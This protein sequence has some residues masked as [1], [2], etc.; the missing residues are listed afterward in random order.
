L[1]TNSK[2]LADGGSTLHAFPGNRGES[3]TKQRSVQWARGGCQLVPMGIIVPGT[4]IFHLG[5]KVAHLQ[6]SKRREGCGRDETYKEK[7]M[8]KKP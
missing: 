4:K 1:R 8:E 5:G 2:K 6:N 7:T 3:I